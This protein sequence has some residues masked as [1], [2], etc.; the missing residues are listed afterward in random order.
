MGFVVVVVVVGVI[1]GGIGVCP[2]EFG[3][4][5]VGRIKELP[6]ILTRSCSA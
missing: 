2:A 5:F 3:G 4:G 6:N 1:T